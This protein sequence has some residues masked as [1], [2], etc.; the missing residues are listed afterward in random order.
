MLEYEVTNNRE[1]AVTVDGLDVLPPGVATTYTQDDADMF[2]HVRGLPLT[3]A[4][5]P[6]D[7]VVTLVVIKD[8]DEEVSE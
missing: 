8:N 6:E 5:M 2:K 7:V 1:E 3:T 4:N